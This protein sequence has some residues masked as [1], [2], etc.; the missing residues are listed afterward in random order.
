MLDG[1]T[2]ESLTT[3]NLCVDQKLKV[4]LDYVMSTVTNFNK[5]IEHALGLQRQAR[6]C[7]DNVNSTESLARATS[8]AKKVSWVNGMK[9]RIWIVKSPFSEHIKLYWKQGFRAF[10]LPLFISINLLLFIAGYVNN[11]IILFYHQIELEVTRML[12]VAF[13]THAFFTTQFGFSLATFGPSL[14]VCEG[15]PPSFLFLSYLSYTKIKTT[16]CIEG[17]MNEADTVNSTTSLPTE[18][19]TEVKSEI[20]TEEVQ[21]ISPKKSPIPSLPPN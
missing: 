21:K 11:S 3:I 2:Y 6:A 19:I 14:T 5:T 15:K 4:I 9:I 16:N 8:C 7:F 18:V 17:K 10:Q 1:I 13:P 20:T 12:A